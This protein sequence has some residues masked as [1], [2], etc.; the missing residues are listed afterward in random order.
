M[1]EKECRPLGSA[2]DRRMRPSPS[3]TSTRA[4]KMSSRCRLSPLSSA[5][6][7]GVVGPD[8]VSPDGSTYETNSPEEEIRATRR[9]LPSSA[10]RSPLE[11]TATRIG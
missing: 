1:S 9:S 3:S 11:V 8:A 6:A 7:L 4:W 10:I 2:T 5:I